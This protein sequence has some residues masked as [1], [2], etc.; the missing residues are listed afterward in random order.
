M[1]EG[2]HKQRI[3]NG[4]NL[5]I[6]IL[7]NIG[8][9]IAQVIG[10]LFSG[11]MAL[12]SDAAHNFSDVLTLIVSLV[13]EKLSGRERTLRQTYGYKRAGIFAAFINA[14]TLLII[15]TILVWESVYRIIHPQPIAGLVVIYL[16]ALGILL[17]G[18]SVLLIKKDAEENM[19][20]HS[21][22][23]HLFTDMMTSIAVFA[24][25]FAIKFLGWFWIDGVLSI[26]IA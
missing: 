8:I 18:L 20:I 3:L 9:T 2:S 24:G 14:A 5:F 19:N 12:L 26:G 13:A 15:A 1:S 4:K 17:N 25:G 7:L 11:S 22:Y 16:A 21:A 10:G 6:T 23:L